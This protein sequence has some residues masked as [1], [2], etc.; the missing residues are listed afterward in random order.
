MS[1]VRTLATLAAG[2]AAAR[3]VEKYRQ[4]GGMDGIRRAVEANPTLAGNATVRQALDA[5]SGLA[6]KA[7]QGSTAASSGMQEMMA[8]LTGAAAGGAS[9]SA[10]MID[11]LTGTGAATAAVEDNARLM[12]RAMIMAAKADGVIDANERARIESQL[13]ESTAEERAF[14][15]AEMEKPMDVLALAR[16]VEGATRAQVYSAAASM[17]R[18][19]SPAEVQ[20][21]AALGGALQLDLATRTMLHA[22]LGLPAPTA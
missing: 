6:G 4:M 18:G 22:S 1:F 9:Q 13:T 16:D 12:I 3:G 21:L 7:E 14:V 20:F 17:C 11:S 5:M 10:A 2:F 15:R 8:M 19:D